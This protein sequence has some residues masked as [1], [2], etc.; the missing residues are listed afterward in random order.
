MN[1]PEFDI[2]TIDIGAFNDPEA[3]ERHRDAVAAQVDRAARTV[4]FMQ[5]VGHGIPASTLHAFAAATDAFFALDSVV[6]AAYRCPPSVNRGY[7][8][9]KS[10]AL[11]ASLGLVSAADLFEAFNIGTE[12]AEY[13]A[14]TLP[15]TDYAP[16][17]WPAEVPGFAAAVGDWFAAAGSVARTMV[18]IFGRALGL[19]DDGLVSVTDHSLDVLRMINYRLPSPETVLEPDQVGMGAH[20]DYGIVTV[21]WADAVPG[22]EVLGDGGRWHPV[23]PAPGAL[24]VN[25]G[26]ALARWT[27]DEWISTMHRVA[28]P[29]IGGVLVPRRSAAYFHDGNIDA[30]IAPLSTCVGPG[31]PA[32]YE[33]VTVGEHLRAK[34]A[35]S[36]SRVLNPGA[37]REA[38]RLVR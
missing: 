17:I 8:P 2:P 20:T 27:N 15:A 9:P 29:R 1:I 16:N 3:A 7:T 32:R 23:Q 33:P 34:L 24:L 22:L 5:I 30:V 4:G 26:D 10:E 25:L 19:G 36:R 28:A 37:E 35:G 21:L 31:R 11:A 38:A 18:R 12:A 14:L 13:P 6:K